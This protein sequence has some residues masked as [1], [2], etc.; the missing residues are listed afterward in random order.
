MLIRRQLSV[1]SAI[2]RR[3]TVGRVLRTPVRNDA[4]PTI[5]DIVNG[6]FS[7]FEMSEIRIAGHS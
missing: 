3:M 6:C 7:H 5:L 2:G 4:A 1:A